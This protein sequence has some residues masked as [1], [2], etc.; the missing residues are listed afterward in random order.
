VQETQS[1]K[2]TSGHVHLYTFWLSL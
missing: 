1:F 2:R